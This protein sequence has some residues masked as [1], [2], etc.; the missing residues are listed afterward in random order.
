MKFEVEILES[1]LKDRVILKET[2]DMIKSQF[3]KLSDYGK[4][5]LISETSCVIE[6]IEW[7]ESKWCLA[8]QERFK[9]II[10]NLINMKTY[11]DDD[12]F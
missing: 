12:E 7:C 2:R 5:T 4:N 11:I 9:N 1:D 10:S 3:E 6:R 8:Q